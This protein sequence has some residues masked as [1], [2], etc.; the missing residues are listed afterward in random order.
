MTEDTRY[1]D[2][3]ITRRFELHYTTRVPRSCCSAHGRSEKTLSH[4]VAA[5]F[6]LSFSRCISSQ[7]EPDLL[8]S[9]NLITD[10]VELRAGARSSEER[11]ASC[12]WPA[13]VAL[14]HRNFTGCQA[15]LTGLCHGSDAEV[16]HPERRERRDIRLFSLAEA[17]RPDESWMNLDVAHTYAYLPTYVSIS[18]Y[19]R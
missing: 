12:W 17:R 4:D 16:S 13:E 19:L 8:R 15:G 5:R 11:F 18:I 10:E 3:K 1:S 9:R 2:L 14:I 6:D 7:R